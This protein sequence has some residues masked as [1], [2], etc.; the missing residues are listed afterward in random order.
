MCRI[1]YRY[2]NMA[3][4]PSIGRPLALVC[5][6][7]YIS[8]G[9]LRM[10]P[11]TPAHIILYT[12]S[13]S[14]QFLCSAAQPRDSA[15]GSL[16]ST[17]SYSSLEPPMFF[18]L[19]FLLEL[20]W[21]VVSFTSWALLPKKS[22]VLTPRTDSACTPDILTPRARCARI[23]SRTGTMAA[24]LHASLISLPDIPAVTRVRYSR[25]NSSG[26]SLVSFRMSFRMRRRCGL[27][28]NET[29][30]FLGILLRIASSMSCILL[31][32]PRIKIRAGS[33]ASFA[34]VSPS[35]K[36]MNLRIVS[37]RLGLIGGPL[38]LL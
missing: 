19:I 21:V 38:T 11:E 10:L 3:S 37:S 18:S 28:G 16:S 14:P 26:S 32:A 30:N 12:S 22:A 1:K 25:S 4:A 23:N 15:T 17:S 9:S 35:H 29:G 8:L 2:I 24:S 34:E 6:T 27:E 13:C 5:Q 36:V 33:P 7:P 31:V 20:R